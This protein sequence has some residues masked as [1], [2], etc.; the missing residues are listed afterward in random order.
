MYTK[1]ET[2]KVGVT[3]D[4]LC[5]SYRILIYESILIIKILLIKK[6]NNLYCKI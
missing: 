5:Q 2:K 6:N 1:G 4:T 3:I